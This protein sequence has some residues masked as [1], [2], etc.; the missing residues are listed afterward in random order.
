MEAAARLSERMYPAALL[1]FS[2]TFGRV[3]TTEDLLAL[4]PSVVAV[5]ASA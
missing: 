4:L 2:P 3:R 5:T 1:R